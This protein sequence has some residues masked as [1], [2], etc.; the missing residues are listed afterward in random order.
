MQSFLGNRDKEGSGTRQQLGILIC[1]NPAVQHELNW[2]PLCCP[3]QDVF[4]LM[5]VKT[6][7][8]LN[9]TGIIET[10]TGE[11]ERQSP[12]CMERVE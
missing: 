9:F 7:H 10:N 6:E 4:I 5:T 3:V 2:T 1:K 11:Q 8:Y 12:N